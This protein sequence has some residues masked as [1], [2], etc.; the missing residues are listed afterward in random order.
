[1]FGRRTLYAGVLATAIGGP[2]LY[3]TQ[4]LPE[5]ARGLWASV[6]SDKPASHPDLPAIDPLAASNNLAATSVSDTHAP[7]PLPLA[8]K[9]I[10]NMGDVFRFDIT[11]EWVMA[12]WPRVTSSLADIELSGLRVPLVTGIQLDDIAGSLTYYFDN[13]RRVQRITFVGTTGDAH[14]LA[15]LVKQQFDLKPQPT[16]GIAL[17]VRHW[18]R[19]PVSALRIM[20]SPIIRADQPHTRLNVMLELNRPDHHYHLSHSFQAVLTTDRNAGQWAGH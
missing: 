8:G 5:K 14:R 16:L 9:P 18:N 2:Y 19:T 11:P 15:S 20:A 12:R 7:S 17:Y 3:T 1:M 10:E 13:Q 6:S 4:E